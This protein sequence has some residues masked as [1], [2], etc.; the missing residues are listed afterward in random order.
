MAVPFVYDVKQLTTIGAL[1]GK[2][3]DPGDHPSPKVYPF[4]ICAK[5]IG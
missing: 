1:I 4:M 3:E 2:M 5:R